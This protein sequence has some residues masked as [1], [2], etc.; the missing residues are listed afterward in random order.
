MVNKKRLLSLAFAI[1]IFGGAVALIFYFSPIEPRIT[2]RPKA[3]MPVS[4]ISGIPTSFAPVLTFSGTT[5]PRWKTRIQSPTNAKVESL[6]TSLEPG[7][8][9]DKNQTMLELDT[10]HLEY[11]YA[12]AQSELQSAQLDLKKQQHE[13]T[14][15]L[16]MLKGK[17]SS[18]YA[19]KE[20][21]IA[22]SKAQV[23]Q[24][25]KALTSAKKRLTDAK[26]EAPFDAIVLERFVS[27]GQEVEESQPLFE[28][29]ASDS[30]DIQVPISESKW[31]Q[32]I[33]GL[34]SPEITVKDSHNQ[35]WPA[36]LRYV[37]PQADSDTRQR[38]IVLFVEK[39]YESQPRL[40]PHQQVSVVVKLNE[41]PHALKVPNSAIT[42]DGQIWVVKE[43]NKIYRESIKLLEQDVKH[44]WVS[45]NE[46]PWQERKIV[47]YP[48]LSMLAG[49][50][51]DPQP[52]DKEIW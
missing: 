10:T 34:P 49:Q 14:V 38:Q 3:L 28:V 15:A 40:L 2:K 41:L 21:Q 32:V 33:A 43:D 7:S 36:K 45:F 44:S 35:T 23:M 39:P 25:Q 30:I 24:N 46:A 20:P 22:A 6:D 19:R 26:V 9:V 48:L 37:Q 42:R 11:R 51:V 50:S 29:A 18:A 1:S 12:Q 31:Q 8:Y 17:N 52:I 4:I 16:K 47:V 27:P 13:Q 5:K